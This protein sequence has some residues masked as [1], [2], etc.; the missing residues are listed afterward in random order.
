MWLCFFVCGLL[1]LV[2]SEQVCSDERTHI[3]WLTA[4]TT[5]AAAAMDDVLAL[6]RN[7]LPVRHMLLLERLVG[8]NITFVQVDISTSLCNSTAAVE[9][10]QKLDVVFELLLPQNDGVVDAVIGPSC[11][12]RNNNS[13]DILD[14]SDTNNNVV[15]AIT[16]AANARGASHIDWRLV[17]TF[18]QQQVVPASAELTQQRNRVALPA[19]EATHRCISS[20]FLPLL[21]WTETG[22][23]YDTSS[24]YCRRSVIANAYWT[25]AVKIN[26]AVGISAAMNDLEIYQKIS[27]VLNTS[28]IIVLCTELDD[29][30]FARRLFTTA[31][32]YL[33]S[34]KNTTPSEYVWML[35]PPYPLN[36]EQ[37]QQL[38]H[39]FLSAPDSLQPLQQ[40]PK[41]VN[42]TTRAAPLQTLP[43]LM[44]FSLLTEEES[45]LDHQQTKAAAKN[46]TTTTSG[47]CMGECAQQSGIEL[48]KL[49]AQPTNY[50]LLQTQHN[51]KPSSNF[52]LQKVELDTYNSS[53]SSGSWTPFARYL[54][55]AILSSLREQQST[56]SS[57][58]TVSLHIQMLT[59][60]PNNSHTF[61]LQTYGALSCN[62]GTAGGRAALRLTRRLHWHTANKKPPL[63]RP[64][65][66][67]DNDNE[68][69]CS[70]AQQQS[71]S[72]LLNP[73]AAARNSSSGKLSPTVLGII[74]GLAVVFLLIALLVIIRY[75]RRAQREARL[76]RTDWRIGLHELRMLDLSDNDIINSAKDFSQSALSVTSVDSSAKNHAAD[77]SKSAHRH[78]QGEPEHPYKSVSQSSL[79]R[80]SSAQQLGLSLTSS[81][82]VVST[83]PHSIG[84]A[85]Y[86]TGQ[87]TKKTA[88]N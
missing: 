71:S 77:G 67:F 5:P 11:S 87:V 54:G 72:Q 36:P 48:L 85:V 86:K 19:T 62:T 65:C 29:I 35:V 50:T 22:V 33:R 21:R 13:T 61:Q 68:L 32:Q 39:A 60:Q 58:P 64:V 70:A 4:N 7:F 44:I 55:G 10:L 28:R 83:D 52:F 47:V 63:A 79:K 75:Y 42:G 40:Q 18:E 74:I 84:V 12:G 31:A 82:V 88:Y 56:S 2:T 45:Q 66:G 20:E 6:Q 78:H 26:A 25:A 24:A 34:K 14:S 37:E 27:L 1:L 9:M 3:V 30:V 81:K 69:L 15:R 53:N 51:R 73:T 80:N 17:P 49:T 38:T 8:R 57:P 41:A 46:A 59:F 16:W 23:V 43:H 76:M